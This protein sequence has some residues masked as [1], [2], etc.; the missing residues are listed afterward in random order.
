MLGIDI[1]TRYIKMCQ[2]DMRGDVVYDVYV[3]MEP[4]PAV[5]GSDDYQKK[6]SQTIRAMYKENKFSSRI[7]ATSLSS[8][9]VLI[10]KLEFPP[11][12]REELKS[13]IRLQAEKFIFSDLSSMEIDSIITSTEGDKMDVL[14][15]AAPDDLISSR[16][17]LIQNAGLDIVIM[18][19]D[20]MAL[21][22]CYTAFCSEHDSEAVIIMDIGEV[23]TNF[24][25][26]NRGNFCFAKIISFGSNNI[27][28]EIQNELQIPFE[29][30]AEIRQKPAMW[31][32]VGLNIKGVLRKSTPDLIEAVYRAIEYT[33]SQRTIHD[34]DRILVTGGTSNIPGIDTFF[35]EILG[36]KTEKW[37][38]LENVELIQKKE[39]GA[40]MGIAL[41]L[42]VRKISDV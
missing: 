3:A 25:I 24:V 22:N 8:P 2:V 7:A 16:M 17:S 33:R 1:G 29:K 38:P 27:S 34:I 20:N 39:V 9:E 30:A 36:V 6:V 4:V 41:G 31:D 40:F 18:D 26:L 5:P 15:V 28:T 11:I 35:S 32:E 37:N 42:A 21:A 23:K 13:S 12:P 10:R 19:I 14:L